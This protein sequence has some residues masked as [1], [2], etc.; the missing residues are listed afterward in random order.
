[1]INDFKKIAA[2]RKSNSDVFH[3]NRYGTSLIDIPF[4]SEPRIDVIPYARFIPGKKALIVTGNSNTDSAVVFRL[5]IPLEKLGFAGEGEYVVTDLR[6]ATSVVCKQKQLA[7]LRVTVPGDKFP[8]G[9]V[10][11]L[12]ICPKEKK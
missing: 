5:Q 7:D 9:G 1:V 12:L 8:G 6:D 3:N 4:H 10:R 2:I 11:V